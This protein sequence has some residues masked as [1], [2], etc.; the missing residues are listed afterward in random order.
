MEPV[1]PPFT[2]SEGDPQ[3]N[4]AKIRPFLATLY[5]HPHTKQ[6]KAPNSANHLT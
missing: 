2:A 3:Y 5:F 1:R 6:K 4:P